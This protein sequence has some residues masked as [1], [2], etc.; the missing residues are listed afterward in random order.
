MRIG[1]HEASRAVLTRR[2]AVA[3]VTAL[4]CLV[5]TAAAAGGLSVGSIL[6]GDETP[7]PPAYRQSDE[8]VVALGSDPRV[9]RWR[10]VTYQSPELVDR[11]EVIQP[12]GLPCLKLVL[13]DASTGA[14]LG[15][16]SYCGE[17]GSGGLAGA[18]LPVRDSAGRVFT[19][20][21]GEAPEQAAAVTL[22]DSNGKNRSAELY[23]GPPSADSDF[24]VHVMERSDAAERTWIEWNDSDGGR[25]GEPVDLT[26]E[27]RQPLE[28]ARAGGS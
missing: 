9:G 15:A 24:W 6:P 5:G 20:V 23:E 14:L 17:R 21:F 26:L 7:E 3:S 8:T 18:S 13:L 22:V 10:I 11:G 1:N 4:L 28:P 2:S 19:L 25:R 12:A 27:L 16:R